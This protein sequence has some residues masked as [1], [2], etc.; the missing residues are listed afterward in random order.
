MME[1]PLDFTTHT[2]TARPTRRVLPSGAVTALGLGL[3]LG[4]AITAPARNLSAQPSPFVPL[5]DPA[6]E[7]IDQLVGSGLVR[8][9]IYGLRPYTRREIA[10]LV[11]E[12]DSL[13]AV[14]DRR[15]LSAATTRVLD[16]LRARFTAD[17]L[18]RVAPQRQVDA[19]LVWLDSPERNI[20]SAP[21]GNLDD[22][23]INPLLN[24]RAG[25]RY[26]QGL[27]L[28]I[29]PRVAIP[30]GRHLQF[31]VAPRV[32]GGVA[33]PQRFAQATLQEA[34]LGVKAWNLVAEVGRQPL[35]WGPGMDGGLMFSSSSRPLD[36][37]R[38]RIDAPY[39]APSVLKWLGL[40]RGTL[41]FADLGAGQNFPHA[42]IG[43][44]RLSGQITSYFEMS[45]Q[46]LVQGGGRGAPGTSLR[47]RFIDFVPAF[48][49]LM[50]DDTTQFSNKL[51]G[52]D[53]RFRIPAVRGLQLY[54]EAAFDDM[55]P[56]RW[57]STGWQDGGHIFGASVA[58]LGRDGA[59]KA[60]A[61]FHHTGLRFYRHTVFSSGIA[62]NG[63]LLGSPLGPM[64]DAGVLR[65]V[66]D[67]GTGRRARLDVSVE[68]RGGD[69]WSATWD[70]PN[71]DN[72]RFVV[73]TSQPAEWRRRAVVHLERDAAAGETHAVDLGIE[74]VRANGFVAGARR[75][76]A[77]VGVRTTWR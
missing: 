55:D 29:E 12:A 34:T 14:G 26:G 2:V 1:T 15:P 35:Q 46:V 7:Q 69:L 73:A 37:V 30:L 70:T 16:G 17:T 24:S 11:T 25:R 5:T 20:P 67:A 75:W 54:W 27:T 71:T 4:M 76:Q 65:L 52:W 13:R 39:R 59:L 57:R 9:V 28:A 77:L 56:R 21:V 40:M 53:M 22:G 48:K 45:A 44:Y 66:H 33:Q 3:A 62:F 31:T 41:L 8:T 74:Q 6:Y 38:V 72:F 19:E 43:A 23:T 68:R 42:K 18:V 58:Q 10:R 36:M 32:V 51:A 50:E 63:T 47:E 64:G 60:T 49:Y 61:E